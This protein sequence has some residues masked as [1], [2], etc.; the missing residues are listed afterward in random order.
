VHPLQ[1][2]ELGD[3]DSSQVS[4]VCA[5]TSLWRKRMQRAGSS[6][7]ASRIAVVSYSALAQ[8]GGLVGDGRRV[9]VDDAEDAL[10]AL[11]AR[12]VLGDRADVVAEVLAPGGLDAGEDA[13][14]ASDPLQPPSFGL[15]FTPGGTI[16]SIRSSTSSRATSRAPSAG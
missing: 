7:A 6:P 5:G 9:Q 16:S 13:H 1:P 10:A 14:V 12:D 2:S 15:T 11:L 3:A 8:L 4:S